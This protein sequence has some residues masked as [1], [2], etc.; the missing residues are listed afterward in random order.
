M[1][2]S[3]RKGNKKSRAELLAQ[4]QAKNNNTNNG[5]AN[6]KHGTTRPTRTTEDLPQ[7][8]PFSITT[9]TQQPLLKGVIYYLV[10]FVSMYIIILVCMKGLKS[11]DLIS[12]SPS[13]EEQN[14]APSDKNHSVLEDL[15]GNEKER[16]HQDA[17]RA[18]N[19]LFGENAD[20]AT[21]S[22]TRN[23]KNDIV[24]N[25]VASKSADAAFSEPDISNE[26]IA[27][28][29]VKENGS[30]PM[31][32]NRNKPTTINKNEDGTTS[33]QSKEDDSNNN[34]P[35]TAVE[36]KKGTLNS[37]VDYVTSTILESSSTKSHDEHI[38]FTSPL[39]EYPHLLNITPELR[40]QFHPVIKFPTETIFEP[41]TTKSSSS[42]NIKMKKVK[43]QIYRILDLTS[44]SGSSQLILPEHQTQFR[45][46]GKNNKSSFLGKIFN[47]NKNQES[48]FG[49]GKYDEN[50]IHLYS[51]QM[52]QNESNQ[53]DG[54]DG[55][56]TVH[57]G[58]DLGG[59][60]HTKVHSFWHGIVHSRGYN[61]ELGDYGYVI[62]IQ[63]ELPSSSSS[64]TGEKDN[65]QTVW[66]L[67]G[68]L[69]QSVMKKRIGQRI[70]KG[71]V[72]GRIGDVHENGGWRMPHVHFQLSLIEPETHDMPGAVAV[73]DRSKALEDYPDP[74]HI[75]GQLY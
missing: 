60:V 56:R 58:I 21:R 10:Q 74:R 23:K 43:K 40:Q 30:I 67:Y 7:D 62:V 47:K 46:E 64:S 63:Y 45:K 42:Q 49:I 17:D 48:L 44:T 70:K 4:M 16:L 13:G 33:K 11:L 32:T 5:N 27:E 9:P 26:N 6:P 73:K 75:L 12:P 24:L 28:V 59:P 53:I 19:D 35:N 39:E 25:D 68:H 72:I 57:M 34:I 38:E 54:Y 14:Q 3:S 51:S 50:R 61:P 55:L 18:T 71:Q 65:D 36:R 52:F 31:D 1:G 29:P 2:K 66:A 22:L 41:V 8:R 37:I 69:D 20:I 15:V